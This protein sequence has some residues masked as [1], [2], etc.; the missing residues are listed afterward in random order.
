MSFFD[1]ISSIDLVTLIIGLYPVICGI[2]TFVTHKIYGNG[3]V[4]DRFTEESINAAMPFI[5]VGMI[6]IGLGVFLF[7][8]F[9]NESWAIDK[10]VRQVVLIACLVIGGFIYFW[11]YRKFEKKQGYR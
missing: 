3:R 7:G 5:A 1:S 10:T 11:G 9:G 2:A 4:E 8:L 6:F